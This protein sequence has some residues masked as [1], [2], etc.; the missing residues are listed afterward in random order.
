MAQA[1]AEPVWNFTS[2]TIRLKPLTA[3]SKLPYHA[4]SLANFGGVGFSQASYLTKSAF[5]GGMKNFIFDFKSRYG[6]LFY[7]NLIHSTPCLSSLVSVID[8][9]DLDIW[10]SYFPSHLP[11]IP[12]KSP[13]SV[14]TLRIPGTTVVIVIVG[15]LGILDPT[16]Q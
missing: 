4:F 12:E 7:E 5:I 10:N 3:L 9:L 11:S 16:I 1:K 13:S 6:F 14:V 15:I 2:Q 8:I